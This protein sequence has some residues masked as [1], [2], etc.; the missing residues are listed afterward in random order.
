M[1]TAQTVIDEVRRIIHD[2]DPTFRWTDAE[3]IDYINAAMRQTVVILPE[4]NTVE[5][6]EDTLTSRIARQSLPAGGIKFIK[7][8]RNYADDGTTPQGVVR[9]SEK[10]AL[11]TFE[12]TWEYVSVKADGANYF[13]HYCHDD[14]ESDVYYVYPAPVEDNKMLAVVY[15][16]IPTVITVV[17]DSIPMADKYINAIV[18]YVTYRS[19]TKEAR[20]SL[21][22]AFRQ[23]L[24]QNY[25]TALGLDSQAQEKVSPS[26]NRAPEDD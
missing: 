15:S 12:P 5:T 1:A 7:V 21:P 3:L 22:D 23:D 25:L 20:E 9:F 18:Q 24:W 16:A 6:I 26:N 11:D 19:L 2:E 13:E 8:A 10:D 14:R 17:G 4:A